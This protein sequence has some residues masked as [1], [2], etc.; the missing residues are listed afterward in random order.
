MVLTALFGSSFLSNFGFSFPCLCFPFAL[1]FIH[2]LS[3]NQSLH[4]LLIMSDPTP[5]PTKAT[6]AEKEA[7]EAAAV[8]SQNQ[9]VDPEEEE[10]ISLNRPKGGTEQQESNH[11]IH[12]ASTKYM[13]STS[14]CS[15]APSFSLCSVKPPPEPRVK[16]I[17]VV[18]PYLLMGSADVG[19]FRRA[20][21][22]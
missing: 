6:R 12:H 7:A 17:H 18:L 13:F 1:S 2:F 10:E 14:P 22:E 8:P 9:Q 21:E 4:P 16:G 15:L 3:P 19:Q 5:K 11:R 20:D